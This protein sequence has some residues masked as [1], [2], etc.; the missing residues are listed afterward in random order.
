MSH[1]WWQE[2]MRAYCYLR[3]I[4]DIVRDGKTPYELRHGVIFA[5]YKLPFGC[6]VRYKPQSFREKGQLQKFSKQ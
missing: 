4:H 2:A 1:A 3:N 5:G 6:S